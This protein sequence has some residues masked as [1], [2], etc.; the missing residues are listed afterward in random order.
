[1]S[2]IIETLEKFHYGR[3]LEYLEYNN[4]EEVENYCS[5]KRIHALATGFTLNNFKQITSDLLQ[6]DPLIAFSD[7]SISKLTQEINNLLKI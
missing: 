1:M 5:N 7:D 4:L 3:K 6:L 2:K